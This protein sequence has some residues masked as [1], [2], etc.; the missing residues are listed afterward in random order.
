MIDLYEKDSTV[1]D[2]GE[3]AVGI[4]L[5]LSKAFDTKNRYY[6]W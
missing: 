3:F 6:F 4:F 1:F 5:D 2:R